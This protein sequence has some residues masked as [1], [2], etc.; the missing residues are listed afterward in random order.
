MSQTAQ[1]IYIYQL[2]VQIHIDIESIRLE[3]GNLVVSE[4]VTKHLAA[5]TSIVIK[6]DC[7]L[8]FFV[9]H[10]PDVFLSVLTG[11][12]YSAPGLIAVYDRS[13]RKQLFLQHWE[14]FLKVIRAL[15]KPVVYGIAA[16]V[17]LVVQQAYHLA[18]YWGIHV[19]LVE[20]EVGQQRA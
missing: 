3:G 15:N 20:Y 2:V 18:I 5:T 1:M 6:V 9:D 8:G 7:Y 13:F 11:H 4:E 19:I 17:H 14:H 16:D 10:T 12:F